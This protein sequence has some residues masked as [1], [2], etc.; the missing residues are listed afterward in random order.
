MK[1]DGLAQHHMNN[2]LSTGQVS[3]DTGFEAALKRL[4]MS[5]TGR[6]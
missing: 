5:A 2:I 1:I 6:S 4:T 3:D